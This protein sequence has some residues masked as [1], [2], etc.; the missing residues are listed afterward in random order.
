VLPL[1]AP[2]VKLS[3]VGAALSVK[4]GVTTVAAMLVDTLTAAE[5]PAVVPEATMVAVSAP[6]MPVLALIVTMLVDVPPAVSATEDGERLQ[7]PVVAP[8]VVQ[9]SA[10]VPT[11]PLTE[12]RVRVLAALP[13]AG[14]V[15]VVGEAVSVKDDAVRLRMMAGA[16]TDTPPAMAVTTTLSAPDVPGVVTRV[17][18]LDA[19]AV[20]PVRVTLVGESV[21]E[22]VA[23]PLTFVTAQVR[24]MRPAKPLVDATVIA[25]VLPAVV[26]EMRV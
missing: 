16:L 25:S 7:E 11:N 12:L 5:A 9:V 10:T 2:D 23:V 22:P 26:P 1:E 15:I 6:T 21:Q 24:E 13:A 19:D 18:M 4:L 3:A 14:T 17:S 8:L 20:V